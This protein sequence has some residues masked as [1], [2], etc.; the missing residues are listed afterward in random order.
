[1]YLIGFHRCHVS[2]LIDDYLSM[3]V[4]LSRLRTFPAHVSEGSRDLINGLLKLNPVQRLPA[5]GHGAPVGAGEL[6]PDHLGWL[7]TVTLFS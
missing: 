4:F 6:D 3:S 5:R 1:M 7:N 2:A